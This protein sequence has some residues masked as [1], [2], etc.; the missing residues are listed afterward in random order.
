V[1][2]LQVPSA[3]PSSAGSVC[4]RSTAAVSTAG[5]TK[6]SFKTIRSKLNIQVR[7]ID[8]LDSEQTPPDEV[9]GLQILCS[10]A[11]HTP[12]DLQHIFLWSQDTGTHAHKSTKPISSKV[13]IQ[14][15][16]PDADNTPQDL[17][18]QDGWPHA[19]KTSKPI[20]SKL[21]VQM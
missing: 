16:W 21:K 10:N 1:D 2:V 15:R 20:G 5:V 19:H 12:L 7:W 14:T 18:V 13:D 8:P 17:L 6:I 4:I 9:V 3:R 11:D